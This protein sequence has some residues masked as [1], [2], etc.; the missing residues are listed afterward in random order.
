MG[1]DGP[2]LSFDDEGSILFDGEKIIVTVP[3]GHEALNHLGTEKEI[4]F[5]VV[6]THPSHHQDQQ[7]STPPPP[8]GGN[9]PYQSPH[10]YADG[11]GSQ[12]GGQGS[13]S[14]SGEQGGK[15]SS[16]DEDST[17]ANKA[18]DETHAQVAL[19]DIAEVQDEF[20]TSWVFDGISPDHWHRYNNPD[21]IRVQQ[22]MEQRP[23]IF[24][25]CFEQAES[26]RSALEFIYAEP[27]DLYDSAI[28]HLQHYV[29]S[30]PDTRSGWWGKTSDG[31]DSSTLD[32][33][34]GLL[35][36]VYKVEEH[37]ESEYGYQIEWGEGISNADKLEQ[38]YNLSE[39]SS[40]IVDYLDLVY[41]DDPN[42]TGKEAFR[43][44]FSG[45][46]DDSP[47][48]VNLGADAYFAENFSNI[49]EDEA[50]YYGQVP[51]SGPNRVYLGSKV[52]IPTI[53]HEFGHVI[54][55]S[56][57]FTAYLTELVPD[58]RKPS[59]EIYRIAN[60]TANIGEEF[61]EEYPEEYGDFTAAYFA[62][63]LD[64]MVQRQIIEGFV[65]KQYFE[66]ELW[67]DLFMTA[68]LDPAV[69]GK[70]FEVKSIGDDKIKRPK[71]EVGEEEPAAFPGTKY[72][73]DF[74]SPYPSSGRHFYKCSDEGITCVTLPVMWDA[75]RRARVAR[76]YLLRVFR[77]LLSTEGE[78][79]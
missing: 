61:I 60:E 29:S 16:Q 54:D 7:A 4:P 28:V 55:K 71:P 67:A 41:K 74:N 51:A 73:S 65:G 56:K 23:L 36:T 27:P 12:S 19:R 76:E 59:Q 8:P 68:V 53:V 26:P 10:D 70:T 64:T 14:G 9:R 3:V 21:V 63:N 75:T 79:K 66:Q 38:L 77:E 52:D 2:A 62:F 57:G 18:K 69:S 24:K 58:D 42:T 32:I 6:Y 50:G 33:D 5:P 34:P 39:S 25:R 47:L 31:E 17:D 37:L 46:Q 30:Q 45:S 72:F 78:D 35:S 43:E 15:G 20:G 48:V 13:S 44:H 1:F 22:D 49:S 40:H 11:P